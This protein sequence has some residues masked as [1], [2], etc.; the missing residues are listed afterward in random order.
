MKLRQ[1]GIPTAMKPPPQEPRCTTTSSATIISVLARIPAP[2]MNILNNSSKTI[3]TSNL[4]EQSGRYSTKNYDFLV[5]LIWFSETKKTAHS[6]FMTGND[7]AKSRKPTANV[8]QIRSLNIFPTRITGTTAYSWIRIRQ[9]LKASMIWKYTICI[10]YV[11]I[12]KTRTNR[13]SGLWW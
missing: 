2:N 6:V 1:D 3:R 11:C 5:R 12:R 13:I 9:F 4:T 10:W 8:R 7:A